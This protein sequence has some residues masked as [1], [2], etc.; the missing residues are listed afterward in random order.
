VGDQAAMEESYGRARALTASD[1][2]F[3]FTRASVYFALGLMDKAQRDAEASVA[4]APEN[5][6]GHYLLSSIYETLGQMPAALA[7]VQ[8]AAELAEAQEQTQLS[9]MARYRMAMMMQ[10]AQQQGFDSPLPTET[11]TP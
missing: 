2:D 7:S 5:P 9:A 6:Y 1:S 10:Q 3:Q 4:A 11:P 8:R